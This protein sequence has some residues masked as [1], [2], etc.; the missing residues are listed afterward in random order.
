MTLLKNILENKAFLWGSLA[1]ALVVTASNILVAY[2]IGNWLTWGA[3]VYPLAFF[4][5]DLNNRIFGTRIA[6]KVILIG[7]VLGVILSFVFADLRIAMA[8]GFAFL[9]AQLLDILIFNKL[10]KA[11]WWKAPFL[12]SLAASAID[13]VIFFSAAF[14]GTAVPWVTLAIG[15]YLVKLLMAIILLAPFGWIYK[16]FI[17]K[18]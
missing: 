3:F 10:R 16:R 9:V 8:S 2:P 17:K 4:V 14:A 15:D 12:S 18:V 7:F 6:R 5:T 11:S 1:M 13:T